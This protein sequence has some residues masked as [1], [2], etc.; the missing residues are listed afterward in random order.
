MSFSWCRQTCMNSNEINVW[1]SVQQLH[2]TES[3]Y[4]K[5]KS[6]KFRENNSKNVE[7]NFWA[8]NFDRFYRQLDNKKSKLMELTDG[9]SNVFID[10][11]I[12]SENTDLTMETDESYSL[13]AVEETGSVR[14]IVSSESIFGARHALETLIQT[15]FYDDFSNTLVVSSYYYA[16][17]CNNVDQIIYF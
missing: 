13:Q 8:D 10:I 5:I 17:T 11:N 12:K 16:G 1:P 3:K 2:S 15:I 6:I 4:I 9:E 7:T 14:V